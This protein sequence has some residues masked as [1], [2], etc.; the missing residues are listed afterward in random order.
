[1]SDEYAHIDGTRCTLHQLIRRDPGWAASRIKH[2]ESLEAEITRLR[3]LLE[4]AKGRMK[5]SDY[6]RKSDWDFD[7]TCTCGV[8]A[9]LADIEEALK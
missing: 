3:T 6:C 7:E 1:M 2:T 4:R 8:D 9:I 5:H